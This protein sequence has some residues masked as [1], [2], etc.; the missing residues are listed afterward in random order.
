M[1]AQCADTPTKLL[2]AHFA[3]PPAGCV[4]SAGS[5]VSFRF[6][7]R[8]T[9]A[10]PNGWG[11]GG[12]DRHCDLDYPKLNGNELAAESRRR[13]IHREDAAFNAGAVRGLPLQWV[14]ILD[15]RQSPLSGQTTRKTSTEKFTMNILPPEPFGLSFARSMSPGL[16]LSGSFSIARVGQ[17]QPQTYDGSRR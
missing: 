12:D 3:A 17:A 6:R 13:T 16:G 2:T 5:Q 7:W 10:K 4:V 14:A 11:T 9:G 15:L 1:I 8:L